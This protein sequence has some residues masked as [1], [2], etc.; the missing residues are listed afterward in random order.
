M[1]ASLRTYRVLFAPIALIGL[2]HI[3][4]GAA[5]LF[6][7]EAAFVSQLSGLMLLLGPRPIPIALGLILV[8]VLA[9]AAEL[10][11]LSPKTRVLMVAPQQIV[12]LIQAL[13]ISVAAWHGAYPDGYVPVSGDWWASFWFIIGDQAAVLLLCLSHTFE[14]LFAGKIDRLQSLDAARLAVEHEALRAAEAALEKYHETEFW[15]RFGREM[16]APE[17]EDNGEGKPRPVK[18]AS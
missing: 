18:D 4:G 11:V 7:R 16:Q 15:M 3:V 12:L 6:A 2:I 9:V 13:G 8:G 10:L 5:V 1:A 14:L 17:P